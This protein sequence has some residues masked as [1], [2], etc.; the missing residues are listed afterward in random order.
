MAA[1]TIGMLTFLQKNSPIGLLTTVCLKNT[2]NWQGIGLSTR[3][4]A[5]A[6]MPYELEGHSKSTVFVFES[7][8]FCK[9][10]L[11]LERR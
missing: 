7:K 5:S 11:P 1:L 8:H 9:L 6:S 3:G 4:M 2:R 10:G